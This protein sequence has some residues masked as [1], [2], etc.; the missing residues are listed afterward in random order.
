MLILDGYNWA[1]SAEWD[2]GDAD[3]MSLEE[4]RRR[5]CATCNRWQAA[6][7]ERVIC[8][9]D[10]ADRFNRERVGQVEVWY[11]D[12][13]KSADDEIVNALRGV[14][15]PAEARVVTNDRALMRRVTDEGGNVWDTAAFARELRELFRAPE[16]GAEETAAAEKPGFEHDVD[17]WVQ[18]F[19]DAP[20][21]DGDA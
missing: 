7:G 20:P 17:G 14:P 18:A 11:A 10:G 19:E 15:R 13:T 2:G 1:F 4:T 21:R 9:F 3:E 8:V 5:V 6:R 12:G 16:A